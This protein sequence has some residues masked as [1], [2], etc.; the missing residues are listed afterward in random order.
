MT[1][2]H[3]YANI[4]FIDGAYLAIEKAPIPKKDGALL[5]DKGITCHIEVNDSLLENFDRR[6]R[7]FSLE[8]QKKK[9]YTPFLSEDYLMALLKHNKAE[10]GEWHFQIFISLGAKSSFSKRWKKQLFKHFVIL[11][12][13]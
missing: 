9:I 11:L 10:L 4:V 3:K 12:Y 6:L 2:D 7:S 5:F 1:S 13:A 8:C